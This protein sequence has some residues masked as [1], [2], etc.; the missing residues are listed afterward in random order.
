MDLSS[1]AKDHER[2]HVHGAFISATGPPCHER[3]TITVTFD[4][5]GDWVRSASLAHR[6]AGS[7]PLPVVR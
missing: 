4:S 2:I 7:M 6:G 3:C 1:R 5:E